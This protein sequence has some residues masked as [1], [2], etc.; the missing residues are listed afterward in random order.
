MATLTYY[1]DFDTTSAGTNGKYTILTSTSV[2]PVGAVITGVT[3]SLNVTGGKYST[4]AYWRLHWLA[5]GSTTGSPYARKKV[6]TSSYENH[7]KMVSDDWDTLTGT[8]TFAAE[9]NTVFSS[10]SITLYTK[11]S[12]SLDAASY[13]GAVSVTVEY[14]V[15][16]ISKPTNVLVNGK[17]TDYGA[18]AVITWTVPEY[19]DISQAITYW[20]VIEGS[21]LGGN[22]ISSDAA[23]GTTLSFTLPQSVLDYYGRGKSLH[24]KIQAYHN[25]IASEASD[26]VR[27]MWITDHTMAYHD[28]EKW[29]EC[30]VYYHDGTQW[31][32]CDAYYNDGEKWNDC[33]IS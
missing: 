1:G 14:L 5:I 33:S 22:N 15:P 23:P 19:T 18:G 12:N 31:T 32:Q 26:E 10:S 2:L 17:V 24:I 11:I 21:M 13:L 6:N 16:T 20:V 29:V 25:A 28:G 9:D 27:F 8:M 4:S 30:I 7:S 3:Y